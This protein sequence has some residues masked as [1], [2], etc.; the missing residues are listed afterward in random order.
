MTEL[1]LKYTQ[2]SFSWNEPR[3]MA[4]LNTRDQIDR[5]I[6]NEQR[7]YKLTGTTVEI[8]AERIISE[9]ILKL[10]KENRAFGSMGEPYL[11]HRDNIEHKD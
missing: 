8:I 9:R 11:T 3:D 10:R 4:N 1:L 5:W 2:G 6:A 7:R